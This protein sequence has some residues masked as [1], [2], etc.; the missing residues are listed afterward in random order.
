[1]N[2]GSY[3]VPLAMVFEAALGLAAAGLAY[4]LDI[5]VLRRLYVSDDAILRSVIGVAPLLVMLA[6]VTRSRWRPLAELRSQVEQLVGELFREASW[7]GLAVV[8]LAAGVGEELLFRGALQPL[9]ER[10]WGPTAGL[11]AVSVLFGALHAASRAYFL[12]ATAVGLYLGWLA[13]QFDDLVAPIVV[14]AAYDFAALVVLQRA[15]RAAS[16]L[17]PEAHLASGEPPGF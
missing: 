13:Q 5:P 9:A 3:I 10:W 11:L 4:W 7:A 2:R 14:H 15:S 8:S 1:M 17:M 16:R 12:L 6:Y